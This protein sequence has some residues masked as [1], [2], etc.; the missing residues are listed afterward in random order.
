MAKFYGWAK[1]YYQKHKNDPE[2]ITSGIVIEILDNLYKRMEE[3]RIN[4]AELAKRLGKSKAYVTKLLQGDY[5]NLTIKTLVELAL[6]INESP[7][8]FFDLVRVFADE[9][10]IEKE[11]F[12]K[13]IKTIQNFLTLNKEFSNISQ[14]DINILKSFY[15]LK[16]IKHPIKFETIYG[17]EYGQENAA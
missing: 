9:E 15:T 11:V 12:E 5:N 17:D 10:D 6:A 7:Q 14:Q 4:K 13:F 3:K 2:F 8:K 1:K 16:K